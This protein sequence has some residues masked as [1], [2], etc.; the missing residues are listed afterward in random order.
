MTG[1][2]DIGTASFDRTCHSD[3][4]RNSDYVSYVH[5]DVSDRND[6]IRNCRL[7]QFSKLGAVV[8]EG[9]LLYWRV[10]IFIDVNILQPV[11]SAFHRR[12]ALSR[13]RHWQLNLNSGRWY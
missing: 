8:K 9:V 12:F 5:D 10:L 7:F 4:G 11:R 13:G 6:Y 1:T 3:N 2:T